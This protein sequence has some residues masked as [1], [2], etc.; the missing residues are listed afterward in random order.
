V[1]LRIEGAGRQLA[2]RLTRYIGKAGFYPVTAAAA[3]DGTGGMTWS[4]TDLSFRLSVTVPEDFSSPATC[5][6]YDKV[7]RRTVLRRNFPLP[8]GSGADLADFARNLGDAVFTA[9][10]PPVKSA[11]QPPQEGR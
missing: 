11:E 5:E 1:E 2:S 7:R 10:A 9:S 3:A 6:L 4:T 8:S